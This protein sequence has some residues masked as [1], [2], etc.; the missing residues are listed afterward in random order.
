[1][2]RVDINYVQSLIFIYFQANILSNLFP[3]ASTGR[4]DSF[5][6][7]LISAEKQ[8]NEMKSLQ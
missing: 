4:F 2:Y 7:L 3:F 5:L 1:M 8:R 6:K